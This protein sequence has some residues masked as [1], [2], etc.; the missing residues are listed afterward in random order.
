MTQTITGNLE[1]CKPFLYI[2]PSCFAFLTK[3]KKIWNISYFK[4]VEMFI[5]YNK[6]K[7]VDRPESYHSFSAK[8]CVF[9]AHGLGYISPF[10]Y[11]ICQKARYQ[12]IP[13]SFTYYSRAITTLQS[14]T[15]LCHVTKHRNFEYGK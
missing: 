2:H 5:L 12:K 14:L 1:T 8:S 3:K 4:S 11:T 13:I 9:L 10:P 6:I 7:V 15:S